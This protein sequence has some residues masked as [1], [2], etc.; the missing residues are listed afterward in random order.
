MKLIGILTLTLITLLSLQ[1]CAS[2]GSEIDGA[3]VQSIE[4]GKTTYTDLVAIFG[5]PYQSVMMPGGQRSYMWI[6][7]KSKAKATSYIPVVGLAKGGVDTN[8]QTLQVTTDSEGIV[9]D[10]LFSESNTEMK[11]GIIR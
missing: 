8:Q 1:G 6:Y 3:A 10:F 9:V 11:T 5:T 7:V 4:K 2:V